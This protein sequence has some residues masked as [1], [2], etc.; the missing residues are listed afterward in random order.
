[1]ITE[2]SCAAG[3]LA[4][5]GVPNWKG[6]LPPGVVALPPGATP[7]ATILARTFVKNQG[8]LDKVHAIQDQ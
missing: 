2:T 5:S 1:L 6:K 3:D 4:F 8:E 7:W